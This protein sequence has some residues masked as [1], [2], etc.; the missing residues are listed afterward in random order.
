M[1]ECWSGFS[2]PPPEDL[3][4]L[5]IKPVSLTSSAL[6]GRLFTTTA[7]WE[8]Q[9]EKEEGSVYQVQN[10]GIQVSSVLWVVI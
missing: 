10:L 1:Q 8:A 7:T 3:P 6:A 5:G 2:C 9:R 4:D